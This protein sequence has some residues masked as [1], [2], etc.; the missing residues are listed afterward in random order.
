MRRGEPS[1]KFVSEYAVRSY[2]CGL[3]AGDHVELKKP[4]V[5]RNQAG[6]PTGA[7]HP[8]GEVWT[9]LPGSTDD[10]GV[11]WFRQPDGDRCTWADDA[12]QIADWFQRSDRSP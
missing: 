11:V 12:A 6:D 8:A 5:V 9:V 1:W 3:R 7:V 10:P 4:L 2:V